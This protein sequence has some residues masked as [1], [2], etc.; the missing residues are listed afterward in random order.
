MLLYKMLNALSEIHL[1]MKK[2]KIELNY[3]ATDDSKVLQNKQVTGTHIYET[4]NNTYYV[5]LQ[6]QL[7]SLR[8]KEKFFFVTIT[9]LSVNNSHKNSYLKL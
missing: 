4:S 7:L 2:K 5:I 6:K 9:T 8:K 1:K 3:I